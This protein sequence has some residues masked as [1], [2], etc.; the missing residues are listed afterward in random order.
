[1][2]ILPDFKRSSSSTDPDRFLLN[3]LVDWAHAGERYG[4]V[5]GGQPNL[6]VSQ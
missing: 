6:V 5:P 3:D 4:W 1:M 2:C